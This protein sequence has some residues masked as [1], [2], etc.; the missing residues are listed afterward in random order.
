MKPIPLASLAFAMA[1]ALPFM[2]LAA[3]DTMPL[4]ERN[5]Q[6]APPTAPGEGATIPW[7]ADKVAEARAECNTLLADIDIEYEMLPPIKRGICGAP[8][9]ILVKSIGKDPKV[10]ISPAATINCKLAVALDGWLKETVQPEAQKLFGRPVVRLRNAASYACRNRNSNPNG[11][12]SEHAK[13]NALDISEFVLE[14]GVQITVL[15]SWPRVLTTPVPPLPEA[16]PA[17]LAEAELRV[18]QAIAARYVLPAK[19]KLSPVSNV[20][21]VIGN[22]TDVTKIK[23]NPFVVATPAPPPVLA[24]PSLLAPADPPP[25]KALPEHKSEFVRNIY[26]AACDSFGTTLG[27]SADAAHRNHFHFDM[28][29]R[30]AGYCR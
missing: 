11:R 12:L 3:T 24:T 5:P 4:P 7:G 6:R 23:V 30:R 20:K 17:R 22:A 13:V 15:E 14:A 27:P 1:V 8:A 26:A 21:V 16:N 10:T 19:P 28:K 9:P 18:A 29:Y 2:A 25:R